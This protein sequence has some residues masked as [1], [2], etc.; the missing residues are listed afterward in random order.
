VTFFFFGTLMDRD[1]LEQALGRVV[2]DSEI[3][4]ARLYGWRRVRT[5]RAPY[6]TLMRAPGGEVEG[7][8]LRRVSRRDE[9]RI[10][11]F[12]DEEY[13]ERWLTVHVA[14]ESPVS[15]RVFFACPDLGVTERPWSLEDW[16]RAHKADYL[17]ACRAWMEEFRE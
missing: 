5:A 17:E 8:L 7:I 2:P 6:P 3:V 11:H 9:A 14:G 16:Q 10:R 4:P 12:E 1:V 13:A 15:A